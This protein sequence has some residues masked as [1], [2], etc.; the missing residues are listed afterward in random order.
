[1]HVKKEGHLN[2]ISNGVQSPSAARSEGFFVFELVIIVSMFER[3][4]FEL[5]VGM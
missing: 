3:S 1:M 2:F 4:S 5:S